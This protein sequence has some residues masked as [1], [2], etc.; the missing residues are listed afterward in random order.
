M[1]IKCVVSGVT[2]PGPII[3]RKNTRRVKIVWFRTVVITRLLIVLVLREC[4]CV[5]IRPVVVCWRVVEFGDQTL[6]KVMFVSQTWRAHGVNTKTENKLVPKP[7]FH[8]AE[9][10]FTGRRTGFRPSCICWMVSSPSPCIWILTR[11]IT[12]TSWRKHLHLGCLVWMG[13]VRVIWYL[14]H[15]IGVWIV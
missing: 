11:K 4:L 10:R 9:R 14:S 12:C 2:F 13:L 3:I 6:Y 7:A 5:A 8:V 1:C 15:L